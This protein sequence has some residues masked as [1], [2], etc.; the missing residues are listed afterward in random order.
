MTAEVRLIARTA[1]D[2][3][4]GSWEALDRNDRDLFRAGVEKALEKGEA[5]AIPTPEGPTLI[6]AAAVVW[7]RF[8]TQ[9]A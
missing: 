8:E 1:V 4:E 3:V 6:P 5:I 7:V 2:T 9:D